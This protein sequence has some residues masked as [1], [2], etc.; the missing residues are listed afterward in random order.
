MLTERRAR[1]SFPQAK[2]KDPIMSPIS[3]RL[4]LACVLLAASPVM[5]QDDDWDFAENPEQK[6]AVAMVRYDAGQSIVVQCR[7]GVLTT[8]ISGL[9]AGR[10]NTR[11]LHLQRSD[12]RT[13]EPLFHV[14]ENAG[15]V[16]SYIGHAPGR[17]AR[18]LRRGGRLAVS[19]AADG[20]EP[21]RAIFD[22]PTQWGAVDRVLAACGR[23]LEHPRDDIR[24]APAALEFGEPLSRRERRA[25]DRRDRTP[26]KWP[27]GFTEVSC[28]VGAERLERCE[29]EFEGGEGRGASAIADYE[30][31]AVRGDINGAAVGSVSYFQQELLLV[32]YRNVPGD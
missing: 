20:A 24:R 29:S 16:F 32:V 3:F 15:G 13:D 14:Q 10:K 7:D 4:G 9:P 21:M 1:L 18:F 30:G 26:R 23:P 2:M 25:Q 28:L 8:L 27:L 5:A 31:K 22:L 12:G 6:L 11:R 19:G 17:D